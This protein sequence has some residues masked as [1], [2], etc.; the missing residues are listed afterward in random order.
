M[1]RK[2][3]IWLAIAAGAAIA[4]IT[5]WLIASK[6]GKEIRKKAGDKLRGQNDFSAAR[7]G[8]SFEESAY[9]ESF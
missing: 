7:N 9:G 2:Q 6:K 5:A 3:G 8:R 1:K 4:G